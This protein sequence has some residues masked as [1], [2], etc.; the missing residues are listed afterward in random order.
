MTNILQFHL[1]E[2]NLQ[3]ELQR[4]KVEQS[5]PGPGVTGHGESLFSDDRGFIW[6]AESFRVTRC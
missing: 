4:Q 2:V 5:F 6:D 1:Y 3:S